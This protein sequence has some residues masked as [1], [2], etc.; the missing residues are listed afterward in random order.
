MR[1]RPSFSADRFVVVV[2]GGERGREARPVGSGVRRGAGM[3]R[4]RGAESR[5]GGRASESGP[6]GAA[7]YTP[8]PRVASCSPP[9]SGVRDAWPARHKGLGSL[10]SGGT[11]EIR[12]MRPHGTTR[13]SPDSLPSAGQT[14]ST[15]E[16]GVRRRTESESGCRPR[17]RAILLRR[18]RIPF[19]P[20]ASGDEGSPGTRHRGLGFVERRFR[21]SP[22][23]GPTGLSG[24]VPTHLP[25]RS[26]TPRRGRSGGRA[27]SES[28]RAAARYRSAQGSLPIRHR[29]RA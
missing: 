9:P 26:A 29:P 16:L 2:R 24:A 1:E 5:S 25:G 11:P 15:R 4:V 10:P 14:L 13:R 7:G 17:Q 20:R 19:P 6:R 3:A 27:A 22:S 23:G 8:V 12:R 28:A 21:G 18:G